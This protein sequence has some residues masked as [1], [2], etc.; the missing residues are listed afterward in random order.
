MAGN[1]TVYN[2]D[3]RLEFIQALDALVRKVRRRKHWTYLPI[4]LCVSTLAVLLLSLIAD[5]FQVGLSLIVLL[6]SGVVVFLCCWL[7]LTRS[8][9]YCAINQ[10]NLVEHLNR[11]LPQFEDAL[12]LLLTDPARLSPLQRLQARRLYR[13]FEAARQQQLL[14]KKLPQPEYRRILS[15]AS[16]W[17]ALLVGS[18]LLSEFALNK[19][20]PEKYSAGLIQKEAIVDQPARLLASSLTVTPPV[21][22]GRV[23]RKTG[24]LDLT[25]SEGARVRWQLEFSEHRGQYFWL[26][27]EG[28]RLAFSQAEGKTQVLQRQFTQSG[29]YRLLYRDGEREQDLPGVYSLKVIKDKPSEIKIT[30]PQSSLL[31]IKRDDDPVFTLQAEVRDDYGLSKLEIIASVAK[32]QGESVKFRDRRF[33]LPLSPESAVRQRLQRRID[34][35]DLEM[36]PGDEVY[37]NLIAMDN[38]QPQAQRSKSV[39]V[40]VRWL[41]EEVQELAS[42][43]LKIYAVPEFFRSQR[44]IIIETEALIAEKE[45]N[46]TTEFEQTSS[47]LGLSQRHLREKY[48]AHLGDESSHSD[49]AVNEVSDTQHQIDGEDDSFEPA[50]ADPTRHDVEEEF[51]GPQALNADHSGAAELIERFVHNH[52]EAEVGPLSDADPKSWMKN[53][54]AQMWQAE[55]YLMLSEPQKALP[56]EYRAYEYLKRA[57]QADKIYVKRLG[58]EPPPVSLD[59]RLSGDLSE[60]NSYAKQL[61]LND[62]SQKDRTLFSR[63][64]RILSEFAE[65]N[66]L[67]PEQH[68]LFERLKRRLLAMSADDLSLLEAATDVE[69]ILLSSQ[70]DYEVCIACVKK[71]RRVIWR[72][73]A[74]A[75]NLAAVKG[76]LPFYDQLTSTNYLRRFNQLMSIKESDLSKTTKKSSGERQ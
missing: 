36:E 32:G 9:S 76:Q 26:G 59:K 60:I 50:H 34:L 30:Q 53:S 51:Q 38:K 70:A 43:G 39:S 67:S 73:L 23:A 29:F 68:D 61:T 41:D 57:R 35:R 16:L 47:D 28:D 48:G 4:A 52:G 22:T 18:K 27:S 65:T 56:F 19:P 58:F 64:Y 75:K 5:Y 20:A 17:I 46:S 7:F 71:L 21:Y 44:Q 49:D 72:L 74:P 12:Q 54:V 15:W 2:L 69:K 63:V 1:S 8:R 11:S 42:A 6:A 25:I 66:R 31:E 37:L 62:V 13:R 24:K 45:F 55:M 3:S 40:I 33:A 14:Q 10:S